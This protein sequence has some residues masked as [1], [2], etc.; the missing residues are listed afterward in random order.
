VPPHVRLYRHRRWVERKALS[1]YLGHASVAI[2]FDRYGH[3]MPG[4]EAEA[5]D[6]LDAYLVRSALV[7]HSGGSR[8]P[9][10]ADLSGPERTDDAPPVPV[11][12]PEMA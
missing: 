2:T 7:G 9:L 3:L 10:A 11:T 1:G 12:M 5:T 4:N 8:V 6:L